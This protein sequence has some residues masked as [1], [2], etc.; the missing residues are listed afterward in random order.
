MAN[1]R[2]LCQKY[3]TPKNLYPPR[4]RNRVS[5]RLIR[6][7]MTARQ[8]QSSFKTTKVCIITDEDSKVKTHIEII[9]IMSVTNCSH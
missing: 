2:K 8:I 4:M 7:K 1:K 3:S 5:L 9:K 6:V